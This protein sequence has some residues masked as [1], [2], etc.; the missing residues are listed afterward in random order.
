M[1]L[2][3]SSSVGEETNRRL[4]PALRLPWAIKTMELLQ[5]EGKMT[6]ETGKTR[7]EEEEA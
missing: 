6:S 5:Q 1:M 7:V 2:R 3:E 4:L